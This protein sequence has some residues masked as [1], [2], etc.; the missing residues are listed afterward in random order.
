MPPRNPR[1]PLEGKWL[2]NLVRQPLPSSVNL[3]DF[4]RVLNN[5]RDEK[6]IQ[7]Y[8]ARQPALLR[9]LMPPGW[10]FW[11]IDRPSLGGD[12]VPD[13]LLCTDNSQGLTW[14]Y[15]ELE[16]PT[17][18]ALTKSG[19]P[20]AKLTE[21]LSQISDWRSWLRENIAYAR[22]HLGLTQIDAEARG[23]VIIGR[24]GDVP[25]RHALRYRS[26]SSLATAVM[27]Y[28]RLLEAGHGL[29]EGVILDDK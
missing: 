5:A 10:R 4:S 25:P 24:R 28:D 20:T 22:S 15:V 7:E 3:R 11:C 13:F 26:T 18:R 9:P 21:G 8:L 19:R 29:L 23:V 1:S 2:S 12:Y 16:S 17:H 14:S 6:P 27:S